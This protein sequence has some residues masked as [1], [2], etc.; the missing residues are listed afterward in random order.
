MDEIHCGDCTF[1]RRV[2]MNP[3]QSEHPYSRTDPPCFRP[4]SRVVSRGMN[5]RSSNRMTHNC[6]LVP[7][8]HSASTLR[9]SENPGWILK[10]KVSFMFVRVK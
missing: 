5:D 3:L 1:L 2:G 6:R 9:A 10:P 4:Q 8:C 7:G